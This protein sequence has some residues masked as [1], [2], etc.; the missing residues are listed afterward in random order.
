VGKA[1]GGGGYKRITEA[2]E[3]VAELHPFDTDQLALTRRTS[4]AWV[5]GK[6]CLGRAEATEGGE[7]IG[8][9]APASGGGEGRGVSRN[10]E[11]E[12]HRNKPNV[13]A[14]PATWVGVLFRVCGR[15]AQAL[16][17]VEGAECS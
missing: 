14:L 17:S 2:R 10:S 11:V 8:L 16:Q 9:G 13:A 6:R 5:E 15:F 4:I 1:Q 3:P 7:E 12:L